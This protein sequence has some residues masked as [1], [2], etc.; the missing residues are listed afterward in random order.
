MNNSL[1]TSSPVRRGTSVH[2]ADHRGRG[3]RAP[4]PCPRWAP[5]SVC[6]PLYAV[7][8]LITL[9]A[10]S[11]GPSAAQ[12]NPSTASASPMTTTVSAPPSTTTIVAQHRRRR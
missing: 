7:A 12:E 9:A 5:S 6:R 11:A 1:H 2:M 3:L 4:L 8:V 10:C